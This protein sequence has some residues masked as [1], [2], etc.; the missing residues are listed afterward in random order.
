MSPLNN[1][2]LGKASSKGHF[3]MLKKVTM[4]FLWNYLLFPS[5]T[6]GIMPQICFIP[7]QSSSARGIWMLEGIFISKH[8]L[9]NGNRETSLVTTSFERLRQLQCVTESHLL[10]RHYWCTGMVAAIQ[11]TEECAVS[12]PQPFIYFLPTQLWLVWFAQW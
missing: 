7:L 3:L 4:I 5:Q 9:G 1:L 6:A 2:I 12:D 10:L 8:K 11:G